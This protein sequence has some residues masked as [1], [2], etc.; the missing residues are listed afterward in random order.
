[1]KQKHLNTIRSRREDRNRMKIRGTKDRPRLSVFRSNK[2]TYLQ[3]ID[4]SS[5][6]TVISV[7]SFGLNNRGK[8]VKKSDQAKELGK[9]LA[10]K[11]KAANVKTAVFDR[12]SYRYHG[13]V[14]AV[15]EAAREGGLKL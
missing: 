7:S 15:A 3:L 11:A 1:M 8:G 13:R 4:D 5:G 12:G 14:K 6:R 9:M 2:Y 10:E